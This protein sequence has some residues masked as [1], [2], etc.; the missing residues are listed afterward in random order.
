MLIISMFPTKRLIKQ[1]C[2]LTTITL[3]GKLMFASFR[4]IMNLMETIVTKFMLKA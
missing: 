3:A 1:L 4:L 2:S